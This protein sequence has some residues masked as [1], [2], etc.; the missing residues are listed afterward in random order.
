VRNLGSGL[1]G[2]PGGP[3]PQTSWGFW[4]PDRG[5]YDRDRLA[6]GFKNF[7]AF[8]LASSE[9]M[10]ADVFV[11]CDDRLHAAARRHAT[12]LKVRVIDPLALIR[13]LFP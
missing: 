9:L 10:S 8:H 13:E 1:S 5:A 11:T 4:S 7:D 2:E 3:V 12:V 6:L